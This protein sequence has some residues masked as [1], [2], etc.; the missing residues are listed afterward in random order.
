MFDRTVSKTAVE[1]SATVC[2]VFVG[3]AMIST[4]LLSIT[5]GAP[6]IDILYE[7]ISATATVG[8][9]RGITPTLGIAG[10][11]IIIATMYLGRVG[12][13]SLAL[14]LS[15]KKRQ[16]IIKNPVEDISVG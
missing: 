3:I 9:T 10:K 11:I 16:N 15:G 1:K 12:P 6:L 2:T 7:T 14:A 13:I 4:L 5:E 8:L